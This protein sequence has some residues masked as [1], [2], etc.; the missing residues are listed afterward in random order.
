[1]SNTG[2]VTGNKYI[3]SL[4]KL[5]DLV[6][7]QHYDTSLKRYKKEY[8]DPELERNVSYANSIKEELEN[9]D[10][11]YTGIRK[12]A[13][14]ITTL[15]KAYI[16]RNDQTINKITCVNPTDSDKK[17]ILINEEE[18]NLQLQISAFYDYNEGKE[19]V[20]IIIKRFSGRK[21]INK[22]IVYDGVCAGKLDSSDIITIITMNNLVRKYTSRLY[23]EFAKLII[24]KKVFDFEYRKG[25]NL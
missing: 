13:D 14:F 1:M 3:D 6:Y 11:D 12:Y 10:L 23:A 4:T 22:W 21:I 25:K 8:K 5:F 16:Y 24:D 20:E 15:E 9:T 17:S 2:L 19:A 7:E 18:N